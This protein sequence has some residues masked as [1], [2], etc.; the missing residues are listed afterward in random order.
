MILGTWM[1][2]RSGSSTICY[3][4]SMPTRA[5]LLTIAIYRCMAAPADDARSWTVLAIFPPAVSP[6]AFWHRARD[7]VL[8]ILTQLCVIL[9]AAGARVSNCD[10]V[11]MTV[12]CWLPPSLIGGLKDGLCIDC[13]TQINVE[14]Q[15][16][17]TNSVLFWCITSMT[18]YVITMPK[19]RPTYACFITNT[20]NYLQGRN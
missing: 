14:Y 12:R 11:Y 2:L 18:V 7:M 4:E 8:T 19:T 1:L 10:D 17:N 9:I 15:T 5:L 3:P 16:Y 13:T 6:T 20:T